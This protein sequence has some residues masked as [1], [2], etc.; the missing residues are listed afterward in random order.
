MHNNSPGAA[1]Q[2]PRN[3]AVATN[4]AHP[5]TRWV[6]KALASF[7]LLL[8]CAAAAFAQ[9]SRVEL[10][11]IHGNVDNAKADFVTQQLSDAWRNGAAGVILDLD[12]TSGND[13]AAVKIKSAILSSTLPVAAFV[14]D[15][16]T[17]PGSLIAVSCKTIAMSPAATLGNA[18]NSAAK[19]DFKAAA[20][21]T[22]RNPAIAQGFVSADAPLPQ[23][24]ANASGSPVTL[25]TKVAQTV[26]YCD[27]VATDYPAVLAKM[28]LQNASIAAVTFN[29]WLAAAQWIAQPWATILLLAIGLALVI[30]EMLTW[31][32]WGIA[33]IVGGVL[34]LAIFASH[35][36]VGNASWVGIALFLAGVALL[37]F[38][39]HLLPGHG[40]SAVLGLILIAVGIFYALGGTQGGGLYSL[41][42]ALM[43]TAGILVAFF[44]YL[45]KSRVW[46]KIGQPMQQTAADGYVSSEDYTPL[47]GAIGNAV[48]GLRPSGTG[49]FDGLRL[50]VVTEG[51]FVAPGTQVLVIMVQGSRIV[52][53]PEP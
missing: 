21:A 15:H 8:A 17:G 44:I 6:R 48:T 43:T 25:T 41:A 18:S 14:H 20:E 50:P 35:I 4:I 1:L 26:G 11:E 34:V 28:G 13:D 47:L 5:A 16:A 12:T 46:K 7:C 45:P 51:E 10:I 30:A 39:T 23:V 33:G 9:A 40:V 29:P 38:E 31:H 27:V 2:C 42:G 19:L 52:V 53:R 37:L 32:T 24:G 22:G 3:N 36:A 49:E